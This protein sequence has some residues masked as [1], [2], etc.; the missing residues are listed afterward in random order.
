MPDDDKS[1]LA[2][3]I[4]SLNQ[5]FGGRTVRRLE[6]QRRAA[7]PRLAT[8][9]PALD[10]ALGGGLARGRLTE[11]ANRPT[12]GMV[13]LALKIVAQ[14][15]AQG[16]RAVY[17]DLGQTFD[18]AYAAR[19]GVALDSLLLVHARDER[20]GFGLLRDLAEA[21]GVLVCDLP[22]SAAT[23]P[24][25]AQALTTVAG[26][27]LLPLGRSS[28]VLLCLVSLPPGAAPPAFPL[29]HYATTRLLLERERWL[30][31]G[32]EIRGYRARVLLAKHK[33]GT[34]GQTAVIDITLNGL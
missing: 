9:F 27:L 6:A 12:A 28:T 17:L 25:L 1:R 13:T 8:G 14:A 30:Y 26:R 3:T 7:I 31:R 24:A 2:E 5:R 21:G 11:I 33:L 10:G 34:A 29:Q 32:E 15:Q 19:C 23:T 18:P 16:E 22:L 4:Q 20:Q